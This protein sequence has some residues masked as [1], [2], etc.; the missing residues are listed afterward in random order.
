MPHHNRKNASVVILSAGLSSRMQT[1]KAFL[2]VDGDQTFLERIIQTYE[3]WG[4]AEMVLVTN[5]HLIDKIRELNNLPG[6]L[7]LILNEHLEFGRF[8][9]VKL[10]LQAMKIKSCCFIQNIDNPFT[11]REILDL[12]FKNKQDDATVVPVF[13]QKGGHPVLL[14]AEIIRHL[15]EHKKNDEILKDFLTRFRIKKIKTDNAHV[16]TNINDP[17]E[18]YK[19]ARG[20]G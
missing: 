2:K 20:S 16:L 13:E 11:S 5:K 17:L 7:S 9:S 12:L 18:Y 15:I 14:G 19:F 8:F 6:K 10:G 4:V 3:N 1:D